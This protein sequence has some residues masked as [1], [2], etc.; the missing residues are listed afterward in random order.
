MA[1]GPADPAVAASIR[2]GTADYTT[3]LAELESEDEALLAQFHEGLEAL[4]GE[5]AKQ[6][7]DSAAPP[8]A[9]G[10]KKPRTRKRRGPKA[11]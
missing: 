8:P 5:A 7:D 2:E 3:P 9:K 10:K 6:Q 4:D 11:A 1:P